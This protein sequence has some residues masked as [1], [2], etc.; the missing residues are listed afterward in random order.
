MSSGKD[1]NDTELDAPT[2]RIVHTRAY[3]QELLDESRHRNIVIALDTGSGKTHIAVLRMKHEVEHESHKVRL[4]P[5]TSNLSFHHILPSI[6]LVVHSA[7]CGPCRATIR[8]HQVCDTSFG[9]ICVGIVGTQPMEGF[10]A[11]AGNPKEAPDHGHNTPG[12]A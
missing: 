8:S 2:S 5:H 3:Q 6:G 12:V 9:G 7:D 1:G 11:L 10:E 4:S